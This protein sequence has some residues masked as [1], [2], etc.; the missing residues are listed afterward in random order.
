[1]RD[2]RRRGHRLRVGSGRR[3]RAEA[4]PGARARRR[5][6]PAA[7]RRRGGTDPRPLCTGARLRGADPSLR[8]HDRRPARASHFSWQ[9]RP[10]RRAAAAELPDGGQRGLVSL[11]VSGEAPSLAGVEIETV[12]LDLGR[13]HASAARAARGEFL[14]AV[15]AD[16][17]AEIDFFTR[18]I[19]VLERYA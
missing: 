13:G 3:P 6:A 8:G 16:V 15:G 11:L 18:A 9:P 14:G 5:G 10:G 2:A 19:A 4:P 17:S 12:A 1:G 7:R